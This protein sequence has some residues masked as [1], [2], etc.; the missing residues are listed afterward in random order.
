[1]FWFHFGIQIC[2]ILVLM[3]ITLFE[4]LF[5]FKQI[6]EFEKFVINTMDA[7]IKMEISNIKVF[8]H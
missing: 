4:I 1:M 7:Q 6:V 3:L 8:Y 5:M 2:K